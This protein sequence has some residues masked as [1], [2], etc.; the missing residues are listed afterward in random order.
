MTSS[1][2]LHQQLEHLT[3][4]LTTT[5]SQCLGQ[6]QVDASESLC[7]D[8]PT[9]RSYLLHHD[10]PEGI[11]ILSLDLRYQIVF[12]EQRMEFHY[13]RHI[14]LAVLSLNRRPMPF[15]SLIEVPRLD[16]GG[17]ALSRFGLDFSLREIVG[18]RDLLSFNG[19]IIPA[20]NRT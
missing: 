8:D 20:A 5:R 4:H 1:S 18:V 15:I 7:I 14:I 16:L 11:E 10:L 6:S 13:L 2:D 17:S 3:T 9:Y 19:K 12:P